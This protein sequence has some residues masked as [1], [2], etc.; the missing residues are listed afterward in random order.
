[1]PRKRLAAGSV[2]A[3]TVDTLQRLSSLTSAAGG[4]AEGEGGEGEE[5][6]SAPALMVTINKQRLPTAIRLL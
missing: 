5:M 1:M 6:F 3:P 4:G 2:P